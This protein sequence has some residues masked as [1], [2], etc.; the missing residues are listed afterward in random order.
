[1]DDM[2]LSEL[3]G[4][5]ILSTAGDRVGSV[6]DIIL[7]FDEGKVASLLIKKLENISRADN[8]SEELR[9]HSVNF[10]RVKNMSE[11]IVVGKEF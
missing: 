7:D 10:N 9:K 11:A 2:L 3:Y 4:K 8:V 5:N 1:M 6:E